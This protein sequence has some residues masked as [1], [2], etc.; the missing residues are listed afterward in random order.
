M[1]HTKEIGIRKVLGASLSSLIMLLNRQTF[2]LILIALVVA[3][4]LSYYFMEQWLDGFA[5]HTVIGYDLF[6]F[7]GG[8]CMLIVVLTVLYHSVKS[9]N[10]NPSHLLREE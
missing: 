2:W 10:I 8:I 1:N 5:Y 6:L 9:S 4:P 3:I 7:S